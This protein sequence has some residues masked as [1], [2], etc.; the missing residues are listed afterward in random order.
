MR[1]GIKKFQLNRTAS[2]RKAL[3]AN[4]ACALLKERQIHT[5]LTKARAVRPYVERMITFAKK[6]DLASRRHVLRYLKQKDVVHDLFENIGPH[7][8][9]RNGG[10]TRILKLGQRRG[11]AAPVAIL[12]LVD[13]EAIKRQEKEE[14]KKAAPK[15]AKKKPEEKA[16]AAAK[17]E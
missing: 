11:D 15:K 8:A 12:E 13:H 3:Y 16:E 5:T 17:G 1:H 9:E 14:R 10:Y 4:M 7:F 2:H 6:G